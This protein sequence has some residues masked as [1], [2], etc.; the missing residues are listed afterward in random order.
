MQLKSGETLHADFAVVSIG[1]R[2]ET[3]LALAAGIDC[4]PRGGIITNPHMQT[5]DPD[6][7]AVG[8]VAQVMDVV[9]GEAT[10]TLRGHHAAVKALAFT[11]DGRVL[12]TAGEDQH[13]HGRSY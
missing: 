10:A 7:Y 6:V 4:G 9:T 11:A 2:P 12:A 3:K 13:V 1:V 8:D 5:N